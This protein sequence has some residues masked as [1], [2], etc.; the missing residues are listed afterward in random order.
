MSLVPLVAVIMVF[1]IPMLGILF[2]G[3]KEW[4]EFKSKYHEPGISTQDVEDRLLAMKDR[5]D[6][7]E[8]DRRALRERVQ[9]LETIITSEAWITGHE[10][11]D[12]I[13]AADSGTLEASSSS[14][15]GETSESDAVRTAQIARRLRG[16]QG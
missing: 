12:E 4:L 5:M 10:D 3:Y 13:P 1:A 9:N 2:A 15:D 7:L 6:Q 14:T 16:Q 8:E 11:V